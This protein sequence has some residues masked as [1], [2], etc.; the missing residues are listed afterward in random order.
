[1]LLTDRVAHGDLMDQCLI[2]TSP[3]LQNFSTLSHTHDL[4]NVDIDSVLLSQAKANKAQHQFEV[5]SFVAR[6][7][8]VR[9][10]D[11]LSYWQED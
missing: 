9:M 5:K 10:V 1:M 2:H 8:Q 7:S 11:Y 6:R 4:T 3:E